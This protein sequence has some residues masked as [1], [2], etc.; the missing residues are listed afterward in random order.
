MTFKFDGELRRTEP[1]A[2]AVLAK[3][4]RM[5]THHQTEEHAGLDAE[6][7]TPSPATDAGPGLTCVKAILARGVRARRRGTADG[8]AARSG[9][10]FVTLFA[11]GVALRLL[12]CLF[13]FEPRRATSGSRCSASSAPCRLR[14]HVADAPA[15]RGSGGSSRALQGFTMASPSE[16]QKKLDPEDGTAHTSVGQGGLAEAVHRHHD[17]QMKAARQRSPVLYCRGTGGDAA[18]SQHYMLA[19]ASHRKDATMVAVKEGLLLALVIWLLLPLL[20]H[21]AVVD[22]HLQSGGEA[23]Q[24]SIANS[25]P[26]VPYM[27]ERTP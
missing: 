4:E 18:S 10:A 19:A 25:D 9:T 17:L 13:H 27:R 16:V 11:L 3:L 1:Q 20:F 21:A 6:Q 5:L 23:D 7:Y 8:G 24:E 22:Y 14:G 26:R 12:A 15:A 2:A